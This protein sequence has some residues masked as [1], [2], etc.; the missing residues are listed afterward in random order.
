MSLFPDHSENSLRL[1]QEI[2]RHVASLSR[3]YNLKN[4]KVLQQLLVNA[5]TTLEEYS[6]DNWDG[7]QYGFLLHLQVPDT[8]YSEIIEEKEEY[9]KEIENSLNKLIK[10][11]GESID[12]VSIEMRLIENDNWRQA[13]G[14]LI[15]PS[16]HIS[17]HVL[18]RIWKPSYLRVFLSHKAEYK[19][20]AT[21]LKSQLEKYGI[22]SFVAHTDIQPTKE[23]VQEIEYALLSMDVLV[24][25]MTEDFNDSDW[26]DQEVGV[27]V[28]RHTLIIP[29]NILKDPY[30]F[31]GKYQALSGIWSDIP[32]MASEIFGI[33]V[34]HPATEEKIKKSVIHAFKNASSYDESIFFIKKVLPCFEKMEDIHIG[35]IIAAFSENGQ[36]YDCWARERLPY[37]LNKWTG[38][39]YEIDD[40]RIIEKTGRSKHIAT[41]DEIPF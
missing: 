24:A 9:E 14:L 35:Q 36:I 17:N 7:G 30:G 27:A 31:I 16:K 5:E 28:G 4:Q 8:V 15:Q 13:S 6:Y 10:T 25:L 3:V 23:W 32:K 33:I 26:T 22:S 21:D 1:P 12:R 40:R 34:N 2:E 41:T 37:L 39:Q 20:Q 11:P 29:V 19:S 18:E 38:K